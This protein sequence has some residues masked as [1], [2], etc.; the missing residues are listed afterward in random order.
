MLYFAYGSNMSL[1]QMRKRCPAAVPVRPVLVDDC[2]LTFRGVADVVWKEG[3]VCPGAL[4]DIT[5]RCEHSLDQ[6]EGVAARVYLKR[7]MDVQIGKKKHQCLY[8]QMSIKKGVMPPSE[9][10][11]GRIA[12]GYR[13]F[14]LDL[15]DL[16]EA[17]R[18]SWA[19]KDI[20]QRMAQRWVDR[21]R[22]KLARIPGQKETK[23]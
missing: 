9:E 10:Y 6:F 14:N 18:R 20:T 12:Q 22:P 5:D 1:E 23:V 2:Q 16:D 21:G 4:Y 19:D 17:L 11:I 15:A 13:D 8:Y 3:S 7:Y